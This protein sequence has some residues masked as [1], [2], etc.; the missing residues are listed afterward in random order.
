MLVMKKLKNPQ[1]TDAMSDPSGR[2]ALHQRKEHIMSPTV[3]Q[4]YALSHLGFSAIQD[5]SPAIQCS[6]SPLETFSSPDWDSLVS[7]A[8]NYQLCDCHLHG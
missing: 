5:D 7:H 3:A 4:A 6:F 2:F 8:T 1:K